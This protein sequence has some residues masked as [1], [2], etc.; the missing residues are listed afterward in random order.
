MG[1]MWGVFQSAF[2]LTQKDSSKLT[3][4]LVFFVL[5]SQTYNYISMKKIPCPRVSKLSMLPKT[6][7]YSSNTNIVEKVLYFYL[8]IRIWTVVFF[9][10]YKVLCSMKRSN[11]SVFTFYIKLFTYHCQW[12]YPREDKIFSRKNARYD[13][14]RS[15]VVLWAYQSLYWLLG[16]S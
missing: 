13:L 6:S 3:G 4:W 7:I 16:A 15:C 11:N 2:I 12:I 5:T 1:Q 10:V 9:S 8:T 14:C